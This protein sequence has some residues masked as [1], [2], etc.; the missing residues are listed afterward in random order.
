MG[1]L[2]EVVTVTTELK[3]TTGREKFLIKS[4]REGPRQAV[5][6]PCRLLAQKFLGP[7]HHL[8]LELLVMPHQWKVA[9][10]L[11]SVGHSLVQATFDVIGL[12]LLYP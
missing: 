3:I 12:D 6:Q 11:L 9:D 8:P 1:K 10:K 7:V 4:S 2:G 5:L